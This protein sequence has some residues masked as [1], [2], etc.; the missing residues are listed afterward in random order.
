MAQPPTPSP[1]RSPASSPKRQ[2]RTSHLMQTPRRAIAHG[3]SRRLG[4][5]SINAQA[6]R[7]QRA[8]LAACRRARCVGGRTQ[9]GITMSGTSTTIEVRPNVVATRLRSGFLVAIG[10]LC[11][12]IAVRAICRG[13]RQRR[14]A[15]C[16]RRHCATSVKYHSPIRTRGPD[17]AGYGPASPPHSDVP[18]MVG[19]RQ[20]P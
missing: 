20:S 3:C 16:R 11:A 7:L 2:P 14:Y 6:D 9:R 19:G 18:V 5:I 8:G 13:A 15:G 4:S 12:M 1:P 17:H 10:L